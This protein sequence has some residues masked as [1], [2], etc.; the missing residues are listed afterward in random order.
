MIQLDF[1]RVKIL[2]SFINSI[3]VV[4]SQSFKG[5]SN[6]T[7]ASTEMMHRPMKVYVVPGRRFGVFG[8]P[9]DQNKGRI[10]DIND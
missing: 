8:N 4:G 5:S 2:R 7:R 9:E 3:V 10:S 6:R 1:L